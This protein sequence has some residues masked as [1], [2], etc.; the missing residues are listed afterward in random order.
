MPFHHHRTDQPSIR[1]ALL[2]FVM[3][4]AMLLALALGTAP[5]WARPEF[6][7]DASPARALR[8]SAPVSRLD[9][10][11]AAKAAGDTIYLL[12]GPDRLDGSFEDAAGL[13]D[14]HGWTHH[15]LTRPEYNRWH[16]STYWARGLN[17][18]GAGNQALVCV[19][20]N[21]PACSVA[22]TVGGVVSDMMDEVVWEAPVAH[23]QV[24]TLVRLTGYLHHD[25]PDL[26]YDF[27]E[28]YA[29]RGG[30]VEMVGSWTGQAANVALDLSITFQP[31]DYVGDE[32]DRVRLIFRVDTDGGW[33]DTD[34]LA[35]SHGA[36]QLDDLSVTFDG[37]LVTFDDFEPGSPVNWQPREM[38][39][40]GDFAALRTH[41]GDLDPCH[42]NAS[43]QV[44][45]LDDGL[46]VPGTGG[47]MCEEYCYGPGG[48]VV[49]HRGGLMADDPDQVWL[50]HNQV[51][52]PAMELVDGLDGAMLEFDAYAHE[53]F[54][55]DSPGMFFYWQVRSTASEDPADLE[56]APWKGDLT[57]L[58]GQPSY[59]RWSFQVGH[60]L[61]PEARW[62]QIALDLDELG[63]QWGIDGSNGTPAP[64]FDNVAFKVFEV[65]G[66]L[67]QILP[68]WLLRDAFPEQ[69]F[70]NTAD[71]GSNW[72]RLDAGQD[73]AADV[74]I[75]APGDSMLVS[76]TPQHGGA[77][78]TGLPTLHYVLQCNPLFDEARQQTPAADGTLRGSRSLALV[79][80]S[81]GVPFGNI[82]S[83]DLPDTGFFFPGD[84]LRYYITAAEELDGQTWATS[85]PAD[86]TGV[87][88]FSQDSPYPGLA[89]VRALPTLSCLDEGLSCQP[90]ILLMNDT[91]HD[92]PSL[93]RWERSLAEL[94][95]RRGVD[96]DLLVEPAADYWSSVGAGPSF[97]AASL[98]GYRT[99]L[100]SS[101]PSLDHSLDGSK[102]R[103]DEEVVAWLDSGNRNL[104]ISGDNVR[105]TAQ[106]VSPFTLMGR[107]Q[108]PVA[109]PDISDLNG[110]HRL[111]QINPVAGNGVLGETEAWL[112]N[113]NCPVL[114]KPDAISEFNTSLA[115]AT[116]DP[117]GEPGGGMYAALLAQEETE[118]GNRLVTMPFDLGGVVAA[119]DQPLGAPGL[120][121][122]SVFLDRLLDYFALSGQSPA[123]PVPVS[124]ALHARA[125]PNP[126]NPG[127]VI[128]FELPQAGP[129][130]LSIHDI[131]GH[132]VRR[133]LD[134]RLEAGSREVPWNGRDDQGKNVASGVYFYRL[135]A[136]GQSR[137]GKMTLLK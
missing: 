99:I 85:W 18:H 105:S 52:S 48:Y 120:S 60:Y 15:D 63:F 126:F 119:P 59:Q 108:A 89:E 14:W 5:A 94:G 73:L 90:E 91:P 88:D 79:Y 118:L 122:R 101:G 128:S 116:L 95:F 27:V 76:I 131:K 24:A 37:E 133:L 72:C 113:G 102:N 31:Q 58:H 62:V 55:S 66:P 30:A 22:D 17:G 112:V 28:L 21:I 35:A 54:S 34:C 47:T 3:S 26:G 4:A 136:Q 81:Q 32:S 2:A 71:P 1:F 106:W 92:S 46:V 97:T 137:L 115:L 104:L 39:G 19:E 132:L 111:L 13:P 110:G 134:E 107:L 25:L 96:Y 114:H 9:N 78:L 125:M 53:L 74:E 49:N 84:R 109:E 33:D 11:P 16:V 69:G 41:L 6:S 127:T 98:A 100:F 50:L 29:Q 67:I 83:A 56:Y 36:C 23:A 135:T 117:A 86:T 40:V 68:V 129:V 20:E 77:Q 124:R 75:T 43:V 103:A 65:G 64:Y 93:A 61:V 121:A 123:S 38:Q 51:R 44:S 10:Q 45:F 87:A 82:F 8:S 70:V 57:F 12:G 42:S 80:N 130:N 7:R